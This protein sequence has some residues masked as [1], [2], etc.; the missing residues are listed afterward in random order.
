MRN[1]KIRKIVTSNK[2]SVNTQPNI[3]NGIRVITEFYECVGETEE[4]EIS[5]IVFIELTVSTEIVYR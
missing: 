2:S 5:P 3:I 1:L 4:M